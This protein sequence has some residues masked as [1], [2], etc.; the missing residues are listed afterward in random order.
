MSERVIGYTITKESRAKTEQWTQMLKKVFCLSSFREK[1]K[2]C[3]RCVIEVFV[4]NLKALWKPAGY[5][6]A[7]K[8]DCK[9][10][11]IGFN[12]T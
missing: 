12:N 4:P 2:R 7:Q 5:V 8:K 3:S 6:H 1:S 9:I 11:G 10:K